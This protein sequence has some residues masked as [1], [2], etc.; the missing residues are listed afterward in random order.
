MF[1]VIEGSDGSGKTTQTTLLATRLARCGYKFFIADFPCY[2]SATGSVISEYLQGGWGD[3]TAVNPYIAALPF[4]LDRFAHAKIIRKQ[5]ESGA[6]GICNRY[7]GSNLAHQGSKITDPKKRADFF[8]Y[9]FNLEYNH[10][11]IP[12]PDIS[13]VLLV[14]PLASQRLIVDRGAPPDGH[15]RN[16]AFLL[17]SYQTYVELVQLFPDQFVSIDCMDQSE[18]C[19]VL[20]AELIHR[21]ICEQISARFKEIQFTEIA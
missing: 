11:D 1:I 19:G 18:P 5:L 13:L 8:H 4:I 21:R 2:S 14:D 7:V 16:G 17:H 9:I 10:A 12:R 3:P 15:E 20:P 6:I